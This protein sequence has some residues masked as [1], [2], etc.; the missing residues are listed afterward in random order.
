MKREDHLT[1]VSWD[2]IT[3]VANCF[4]LIKLQQSVTCIL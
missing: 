4:H 3:L 2:Q 1:P